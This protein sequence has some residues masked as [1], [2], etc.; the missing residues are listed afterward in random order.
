MGM[1]QKCEVVGNNIFIPQL[2]KCEYW[3]IFG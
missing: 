3:K 2:P 1:T